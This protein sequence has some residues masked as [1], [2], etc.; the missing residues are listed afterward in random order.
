MA[1]LSCSTW[2]LTITPQ[3]HTTLQKSTSLNFFLY[4]VGEKRCT[5]YLCESTAMDFP[6][7]PGQS[8]LGPF[9]AQALFFNQRALLGQLEK[10][11]SNCGCRLKAG[12]KCY[13]HR[14]HQAAAS[15][16]P[17]C[18]PQHAQRGCAPQRADMC[19]G[20]FVCIARVQANSINPASKPNAVCGAR[21]IEVEAA[22]EF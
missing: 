16:C 10:K 12:P 21:K 19:E 14:K 1:S 7:L 13:C 5:I 3:A 2:K 11:A 22:L 15:T 20:I 9:F 17:D 8:G 6:C 4:S 18:K